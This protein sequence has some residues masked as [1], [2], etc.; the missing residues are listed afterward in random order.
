[1]FTFL[2]VAAALQLAAACACFNSRRL[3]GGV[4]I[5]WF[6]GFL[7]FLISRLL[8]FQFLVLMITGLASGLVCRGLK[9]QPRY[10]WAAG[11]LVTAAAFVVFGVDGPRHWSA[12]R[13][14]YPME[15]LTDRL[16]YET[17]H[18]V[19]I[20]GSAVGIDGLTAQGTFRDGSNP[21]SVAELDKLYL[22]PHVSYSGQQRARAL[23]LVH[24]SYLT[25]FIN[26][27]GFGAARGIGV[28]D[29]VLVIIDSHNSTVDRAVPMPDEEP[30]L[31][32]SAQEAP[33]RSGEQ[34]APQA[35]S[36]VLP[37]LEAAHRNA[38]FDFAN[39]AGFGYVQDQ[40]HVVGFRSHRFTELP[41]GDAVQ[42]ASQPAEP[43]RQWDTRRVELVSLLKH[44][45]P[46]VYLSKNLP[47][48]DDLRTAPMR[49]LDAFE[50][51]S[52]A[53]LRSG[54]EIHTRAYGERIRM[55]GAVRAARQCVSCHEVEQG[56]L[57]GAFSYEFRL[58][59]P[60]TLSPAEK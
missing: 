34:G 56:A 40:A 50:E 57:L 42:S 11:A 12:L 8:L 2:L 18:R 24:A 6:C 3:K 58:R 48:M 5:F 1:M 46:M 10:Y 55:L 30:P 53:A 19:P 33:S 51:E 39:V 59:Q 43:R 25:Q 7:S 29:R 14:R 20:I 45:Q 23:S 52:L 38:Q 13:Q 16:A 36:G 54:Q 35:A 17:S 31:E 41:S 27:P 4:A 49:R 21:A 26:S 32:A 9:A 22:E 15:S 37:L 60:A 47:R 28:A 44:E